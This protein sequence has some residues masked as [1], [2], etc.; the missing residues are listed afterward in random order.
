MVEEKQ[1]HIYTKMFN[2]HLLIA[3]SG[4]ALVK[5][6]WTEGSDVNLGSLLLLV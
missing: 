6:W 3:H 5:Y 2:L 1:A 4:R